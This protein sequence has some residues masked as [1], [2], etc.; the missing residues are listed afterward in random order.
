MV[1]DSTQLDP[2]STLAEAHKLLSQ[3]PQ[4]LA[5]RIVLIGGQALLLWAEYYLIDQATGLQ[6][7]L[8]AS[9]DLDFMGR[10]PEVIDCAHAWHAEHRL[11]SPD[12]NA[13]QSGI[14]V[15]NNSGLFH[16]IDFLTSVYGIDDHEVYKYSDLMVFGENQIK[17]LSPPLCLKSRIANLSGLHY[18][19]P[20]QQR[21]VVRITAAIEATKL[22]LID[23]CNSGQKRPLSKAV[24]YLMRYVLLSRAG[25]AISAA[26]DLD[27]S[28]AF[29]LSVIRS[30]HPPIVDEYLSRWLEAYHTRV[31]RRPT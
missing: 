4:E 9:D 30:I 20:L 23:I 22:Y 10:R 6:Y 28:A 5:D 27:L 8:L 29:P 18:A 2:F 1:S 3:L 12:D 26:Y 21:E 17:V 15:L 19:E 16:T 7:E 24:K 25:V 13:P 11:P 31:A 14:V